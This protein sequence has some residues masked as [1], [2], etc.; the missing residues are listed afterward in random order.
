MILDAEPA[1][2]RK[3]VAKMCSSEFMEDYLSE[4][5]MRVPKKYV[6]DNWFEPLHIIT[7]H[8]ITLQNY[9]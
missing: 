6:L 5:G 4:R 7:A 2:L 9:I 1:M 3:K 8:L